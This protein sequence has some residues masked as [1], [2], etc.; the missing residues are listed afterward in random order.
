MR[1]SVVAVLLV[2]SAMLMGCAHD[3]MP[4][5]ILVFDSSPTGLQSAGSTSTGR[6]D[7]L[8]LNPYTYAP[9]TGSRPLYDIAGGHVSR[10]VEIG[11]K[12]VKVPYSPAERQ[13]ARNTLIEAMIAASDHNT[14]IHLADVKASQ[15]AT[16]L[17]FGGAGLG[18]SGAA[19]IATGPAGQALAAGATGAQGARALINE[20]VW[21]KTFA[22]SVF[23]LVVENRTKMAADIR[24]NYR[25]SLMTYPVERGIADVL[26]YHRA[27]SLVQGLGLALEAI[28]EKRV[29]LERAAARVNADPG[30]LQGQLREAVNE[31]RRIEDA[32]QRRQDEALKRERDRA[33]DEA[34]YQDRM[35]EQGAHGGGRE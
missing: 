18:L 2:V 1:G 17:L 5:D 6:P 22:E 31:V 23:M 27:G 8:R 4:D 33:A 26:A 10:T 29:E 24:K 13:E 28:G 7:G 25:D 3:Y 30:E 11:G 14:S 21:R 32:V 19:A 34:R 9:T 16:D 35:R 20:Q 12:D 15:A